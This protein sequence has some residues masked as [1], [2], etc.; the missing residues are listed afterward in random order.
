MGKNDAV[1][2]AGVAE[3]SAVANPEDEDE[4]ERRRLRRVSEGIE[5][6][7][8]LTAKAEKQ[9]ADLAETERA[10]AQAIAEAEGA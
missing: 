4:L 5:R 8:K 9:R 7:E 10:L 2:Q 3:A 1:F 6:V